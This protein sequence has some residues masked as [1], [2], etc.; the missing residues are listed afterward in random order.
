MKINDLNYQCIL[1]IMIFLDLDTIHRIKKVNHLFLNFHKLAFKHLN[2]IA[3][4]IINIKSL[5]YSYLNNPNSST[6]QIFHNYKN[7][8]LKIYKNFYSKHNLNIKIRKCLLEI[9]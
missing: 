7:A 2:F 9:Y 6:L 8:K 1:N 4:M 5:K 3:A